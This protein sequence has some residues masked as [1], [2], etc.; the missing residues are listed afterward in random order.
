MISKTRTAEILAYTGNSLLL[1]Q[2]HNAVVNGDGWLWGTYAET[3]AWDKTASPWPVRLFKYHPDGRR[4]VWFDRG[5]PRRDD[6]RQLWPDPPAPAGVSCVLDETRHT[7]DF[8]FCDSLAYDGGRYVYAGTVAGV[9]CRID[10]HTNHVEKL[11]QVM[12]AG[13]FPAL[14]FGSDGTLFGAGGMK[15]FTQVMR[16]RSESD[17]IESF[18]PVSDPVTNDGP[19]RIHEL[20]VDRQ[21]VLYLAENDNHQRSSY[22][23][24]ARLPS[25]SG[26]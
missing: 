16:L 15:G 23:W 9:L 19:A 17:R 20:A 8:G 6:P 10:V 21:N 14:A 2:P 26:N 25:S 11:A 1:S 22:L 13:R 7:Q 4:F 18:Y 12:A 3:R 5:L 24:T